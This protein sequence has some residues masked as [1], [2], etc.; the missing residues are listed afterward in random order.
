MGS[1]LDHSGHR[2]WA[3]QGCA[4]AAFSRS[5]DCR[6]KGR[7][8]RAYSR[9]RKRDRATDVAIQRALCHHAGEGTLRSGHMKARIPLFYAVLLPL[10]LASVVLA[11]AIGS[12]S[13]GWGTV[14]RVVAGKLLPAGWVDLTRI[15]HAESV[16][17]WLI[18]I[19][20]VLVAACVGAG[21]AASGVIMQALFRNPLAE[22]SLV[23]AGAGAV[24]GGVIAFVA[25]W[26]VTSVISLPLAAM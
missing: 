18:R 10:L 23:G 26:S 5:G 3:N 19:P 16:I 17:V 24:L 6:Y 22:P 1:G 2:P 15:T 11:M 25:G 9:A 8:Q 7:A 12:T 4:G 13:L 21:L 14:L 20:R